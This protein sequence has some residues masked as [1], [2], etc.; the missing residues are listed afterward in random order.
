MT[1]NMQAS[2]TQS[3]KA[4]IARCCLKSRHIFKHTADIF[5]GI[6]YRN[7][8]NYAVVC[9]TGYR[10]DEFILYRYG[11]YNLGFVVNV[12]FCYLY[13]A[14]FKN[15]I[16]KITL[17]AANYTKPRIVSFMSMSAFRHLIPYAF[18][19]ENHWNF[20]VY[21]IGYLNF[22]FSAAESDIRNRHFAVFRFI[23]KQCCGV[24]DTCVG[25][26]QIIGI[27]NGFKRNAASK[28][29]CFD[30]SN[31]LRYNYRRKT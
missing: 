12:T 25:Y 17:L 2:R 5:N 21:R 16:I 8:F 27:K 3:R 30:R 14:V 4:V 23:W 31:I 7:F 13:S 29:I 15:R 18:F 28:R 24:R 26:V 19:N 6:W 9:K 10:C 1:E 11:N 22:G 20:S